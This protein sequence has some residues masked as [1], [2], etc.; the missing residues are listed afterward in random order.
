M[1]A[2]LQQLAEWTAWQI[3]NL[4]QGIKVFGGLVEKVK[5]LL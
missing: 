5:K 3:H 1:S 4:S 2:P